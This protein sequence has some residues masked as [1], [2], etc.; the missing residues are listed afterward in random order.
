MMPPRPT[1]GRYG[2]SSRTDVVEQPIITGAVWIRGN[3]VGVEQGRLPAGAVVPRRAPG[4]DGQI[5]PAV[6]HAERSEIDMAG[7]PAVVG[8]Q[9]VRCA[10]ITMADDQPI[11]RRSVGEQLQRCVDAER[12]MLVMPVRRVQTPLPGPLARVG[13]PLI[14]APA[15]RA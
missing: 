11:D 2:V 8:E 1:T 14:D 15:E 4:R 12:L 7:P 3:P 9:D 13:E 10:A 6:G 5:C